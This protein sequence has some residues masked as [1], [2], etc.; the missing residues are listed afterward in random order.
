[1]ALKD[2]TFNLIFIFFNSE[3]IQILFLSNFRYIAFSC[4]LFLMNLMHDSKI[5]CLFCFECLKLYENN[6]YNLNF[7]YSKSSCM[8]VI[9]D[10]LE[11]IPL[12]VISFSS[13]VKMQSC[14]LNTNIFWWI[15]QLQIQLRLKTAGRRHKAT[16]GFR[17]KP[18]WMPIMRGP[19]ISTLLQIIDYAKYVP[20]I[21]IQV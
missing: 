15:D 9:K 5:N 13:F 11:K 12:L 3:S 7:L 16:C 19:R 1:M 4:F 18:R 14:K 21:D 8:L 10:I 20:K 6:T 2:L 17:A